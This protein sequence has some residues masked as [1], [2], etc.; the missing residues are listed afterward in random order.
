MDALRVGQ[1]LPTVLNA[2]NEIAVE[3]FLNKLISFHDI[4]RMVEQACEA[5]LQDGIAKEPETV[6]EALAIDHLVRERSRSL[7][8]TAHASVMVTK[9]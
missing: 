2:A 3:A 7:L 5:A 9:Q 4:A 8:A 1:G 6:A